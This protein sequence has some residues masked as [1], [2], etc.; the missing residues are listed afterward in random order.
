MDIK[1]EKE[2]RQYLTVDGSS[3]FATVQLFTFHA[4]KGSK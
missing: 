4:T 3:D 2:N 1:G